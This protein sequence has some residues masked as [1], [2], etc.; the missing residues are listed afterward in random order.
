MLQ[1]LLF[2]DLDEYVYEWLSPEAQD[3]YDK[4]KPLKFPEQPDEYEYP[5]V[6]SFRVWK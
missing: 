2:Q 1:N 4:C 5:E 3:T 6:R